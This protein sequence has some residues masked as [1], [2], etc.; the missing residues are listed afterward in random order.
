M[1]LTAAWSCFG[2]IVRTFCVGIYEWTKLGSASTLQ[3]LIGSQ[4]RTDRAGELRDELQVFFINYIE[5]DQTRYV[6]Q[7]YV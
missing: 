7:R 5:E 4:L 3:T 1:F 2:Q 6:V